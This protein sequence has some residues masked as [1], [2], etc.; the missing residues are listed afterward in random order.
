MKM[1]SHT[2]KIELLQLTLNKKSQ[3]MKTSFWYND[4]YQE[5]A[6]AQ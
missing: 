6:V 4:I 5:D 3:V 1:Q 2:I